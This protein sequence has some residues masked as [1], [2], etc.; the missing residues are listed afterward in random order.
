M[1]RNEM[2]IVDQFWI[3][4]QRRLSAGDGLETCWASLLMDETGFYSSEM[5]AS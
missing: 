1:V 3:E 5:G 2:E 4:H